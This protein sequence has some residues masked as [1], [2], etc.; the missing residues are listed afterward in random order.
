MDIDKLKKLLEEGKSH[1][2][3]ATELNIGSREYEL[4]E[5]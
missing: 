1:R 4:I 5:I 3:I 2:Q